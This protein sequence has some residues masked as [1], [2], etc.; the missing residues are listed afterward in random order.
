M[1]KVAVIGSGISGL[2]CGYYL[3]K[4]Y[5]VTVFEAND[6]IGGHTSTS[7]ISYQGENQRIDTGFIVFNDRTYPNFIKLIEELGV[8]YQPTEMSFSVRNDENGLEYNGNNLFSLFAQ[9]KNLIS[10]AFWG[11]LRDILRFNKAVRKEVD[12]PTD[13]TIGSYLDGQEYGQLFKQSYLLPMISAIWSMGLQETKQFP[14]KFFAR[15]FLNHGLLDVVN[16]PQWYTICGGSNSYVKPLVDSFAHPVRVNSGV[17]K[18]VRGSDQLTLYF[19]DQFESFDE[20]V[21]ATHADQALAML[22]EPTA[23][24]QRVLSGIDFTTNQVVLHTDTSILPRTRRAWASWNYHLNDVMHKPTLTYNMN[25]LQRLDAVHTYLVSLNTEVEEEK[26]IKRFAYAHPVY[27]PA[28]IEAQAQWEKISGR[29]R[30]H[31]AGAYWLNGF[32]EDGVA[33]GLRVCNMLG[34]TP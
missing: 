24:E 15:F 17:E 4:T 2:V 22:D 30:I 33:S 8:A 31:Y 3:S 13:S 34:V 6:Y 5:D 32:H 27:N 25:I 18:V 11:M 20:V 12:D 7:E 28:T 10:P 23:D 16:R 29:D 14:L 19:Q 9:R 1:K 26:V 21:I